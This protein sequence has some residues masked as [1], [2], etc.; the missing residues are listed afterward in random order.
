MNKQLADI[1]YDPKSGLLSYDKFRA[2]V[3]AVDPTIKTKDVKEFYQNQEVNQLAKKTNT[4][5]TKLYKITGPE[6]TF[7]IDLMFIPKAIK[8]QEAK[9]LK[10]KKEGLF[11]TQYYYVFLLCIDVLSRKAYIYPMPNKNTE[12]IMDAY[13]RFL[14]DIKSDVETVA[15][16]PDA[17]SEDKPYAIITDD[18]FD[19]KE[20][21]DLNEKLNILVDNKTA[22]N[23]HIIGGNRLGIIDRLVRTVKNIFTKFVYATTGKTYSVKAVLNDIVE[24]YNDTIHSSLDGLTPDKV[25]FSKDAR[26]A[27]FNYNQEYNEGVE[28]T[29]KSKVGDSVRILLNP[30]NTFTKEKPSFSKEVYT[31]SAR[32]GYKFFVTDKNDKLLKRTFSPNELLKVDATK[33]QNAN[34]INVG[35]QIKQNQK[36]AKAKQDLR[37][38]D[39]DENNIIYTKRERKANTKYT[40]V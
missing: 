33:I 38:L 8:T 16:T 14:A 24:S 9:K 39:V 7:Q 3:K 12:S 1:F 40:N 5:K 22:Y 21:K 26:M 27:V 10:A 25:F 34:P 37:R 36:V 35:K 18:G 20:F 28:K 32:G 19:F 4:D 29:V 15:D 6:L 30:N 17:F 13:Y 31:I 2:K 23:D 11:P